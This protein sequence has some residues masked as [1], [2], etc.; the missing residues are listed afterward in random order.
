MYIPPCPPGLR[1]AA[2]YNCNLLCLRVLLRHS[3]CH[4]PTSHWLIST[5]RDSSQSEQG[6]TSFVKWDDEIPRRTG[7]SAPRSGR[8]KQNSA[9]LLPSSGRLLRQQMPTAPHQ[10]SGAAAAGAAF[11]HVLNRVNVGRRY[12]RKVRAEEFITVGIC[13][14]RRSQNIIKHPSFVLQQVSL[15]LQ[16]SLI[17]V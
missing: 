6:L 1:C 12:G 7:V 11:P 17:M 10:R 8:D 9:C 13:K 16:G 5:K 4:L 3:Y 14:D 2:G 15:P